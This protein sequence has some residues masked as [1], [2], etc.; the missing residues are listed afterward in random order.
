MRWKKNPRPTGLMG[1]GARPQGSTL[2][3]G[4]KKYADTNCLG[5]YGRQPVQ[6]WY[7]V[8]G[9]QSGIAHKNTCNTPVADEAT[10][11]AESMAYVKA[12]LKR[13]TAQL[14]EQS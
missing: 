13:L 6:G 10:A 4:G 11:K 9:W 1:I 12:E 3:E 2:S 7:W 14:E 5:G 8:A